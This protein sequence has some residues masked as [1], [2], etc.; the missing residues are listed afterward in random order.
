MSVW[1]GSITIEQVEDLEEIFAEFRG[2]GWEIPDW[3]INLR[4]WIETK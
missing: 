4:N 3:L 1:L 2:T